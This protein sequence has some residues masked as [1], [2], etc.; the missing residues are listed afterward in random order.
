MKK[1]FNWIWYVVWLLICLVGGGG[2][3]FSWM[4]RTPAMF[5][6]GI[7]MLVVSVIGG[8]ILLLMVKGKTFQKAWLPGVIAGVVYAAVVATTV[9]VCDEVIFKDCIANYQPVHSSL[10]VVM[11]NFVLM[12]A[13]L[14]LMPRKYDPKLVW[15]KRSIALILACVALALSGLPQNWWWGRYN[16]A[17]S[18][19]ERLAAPV[20][21]S[22]Y[23]EKEFGLVEDADFYVAVDGNDSN[24]GSFF[25]PFATIEKARDVIRAMDKTG[26]SGITVAVKAGN[27]RVD[28]ITFTAE[29]SGTAE[30]PITY[31]AYGD[32]EVILN[33]GVTLDPA[34]FEAVTAA[35]AQ[36][37]SEKAREHV[38]WVDMSKYGISSEDLGEMH[39]IGAY[40]T[41]A[42][43]DGYSQGFNCE[44]FINDSSQIL[45]RYPN[46][47]WLKTGQVLDHGQPG[48]SND[49]PHVPVEG[50]EELRN[51]V[52]ETY[53]VSQ[54]LADRI[55]SWA[56]LDAVWMFGYFS[57]DWAP[58]SSPIGNFDYKNL[59]LQN[60]FV[61]RFDT[62]DLAAD[63]YFYNVFE[64]LD[65][66]GEWYLDRENA[67]LYVYA[68][69]DF[70]TSELLLSVSDET[71]I[72]AENADHLIFRGFTLQGGKG[73][74]ISITGTGNTV[75]Y[76]LVK[77]MA[78]NGIVV[79]GYDNLI[80]CNE[81]TRV[82]TSAVKVSGGD[83]ETLTP[84]NNR[85]YNNYIHHWTG[86]NGRSGIRVYGVGQHIDHNELHDTTDS[87]IEYDGNDHII[88]YNL[89]HDV[90]LDS[91]DG[92]AIY[93]GRSWTDYGCIVRYNAIYNMG[94]P[95]F[96][97]PNG[98]YLDDGLAG[99]QIYC[100][101]LVN[102]P[103]EGI[104]VGGGRDN[105]VWGNVIINTV[106][107]GIRLLEAV[108]YGGM[109]SNIETYLKPG[110]ENSP[111][112]SQIWQNAYPSLAQTFW[113]ESRADDPNFIA[114][115]ANN[116]INGNLL[117]NLK[118]EL[119]E[120]DTVAVS[121]SDVSGNAAYTRD[122][123]EAIFVDPDHGDYRL[124]ENSIVYELI[125]DFE[126]LP[127]E[128]MGRE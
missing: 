78:G 100:N 20:G 68:A 110:W 29:D 83:T 50:W 62:R 60:K 86:G 59:T 32:G 94:T 47:G 108:Y 1:K 74:G 125:P 10:I 11:L 43:Y 84:A 111:R 9:Y 67:A 22:T 56:E 109:A 106:S 52:G 57:A 48:E 101:L 6:G 61:A 99:Q 126:Q 87:A 73:D 55:N 18:S 49:N 128:K 41:S 77:N 53:S 116:K 31:C 105:E 4:P 28:G 120:M 30:C 5:Y 3:L 46:E 119:G 85:V 114:N 15:L 23:T 35:Q 21:L 26:K 2:T 51:P 65:A 104:K 33:A 127:I 69:E 121:L 123:L 37:L 58:S 42:K 88:E 34:D 44:L 45:A 107:N 90:C 113:D 66:E 19:L 76:C 72:V 117:V 24:D 92:G 98:I 63:Y 124:K 112:D 71:V 75:E 70:A 54:E 13:L 17:V 80:A 95:G 7:A 25:A 82:G 40:N 89:I 8:T 115:A 91:S 97:Q 36:R 96:S 16:Y 14:M 64:E 39:A 27:Y 81:I 12:L 102:I 118:G 38:F 79:A 93:S 103:Q 122:M